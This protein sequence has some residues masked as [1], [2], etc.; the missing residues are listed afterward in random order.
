MLSG[1]VEVFKR[2]RDGLFAT[3]AAVIPGTVGVSMPQ[4]NINSDMTFGYEISLSHRNTVAGVHYWVTGQISATKNRWDHYLDGAASN[5]ME[6]WRRGNVS[7]RNK[8]IWWSYEEGGRYGN[9]NDI[10]YHGTLGDVGQQT[11]PGDYYYKDWNGDGVIDGNDSHPVATYNLPVF[12]YGFTIGAAWKGI[13]LATTWQGVAG[14]YSAYDEVFTE[15]G[16]FNGGA[17]LSY[18]TDRWHTANITDDP[19]NPHTQWVKGEY[20]ATGHSFNTGTTGIHNASY[21]RLKTLEV[22]YTLPQKWLKPAGVKDLRI[23]FNAYNLW[24]ITGMKNM[25]PERP[26]SSGG[27]STG[28]IAFYNYPINRTYN[29]G[30]TLKF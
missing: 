28:G 25:D 6:Y 8:D 5:S 21:L 15:V 24:T 2:K 17:S 19:W 14:V 11:L 9:Y 30:A 26:G 12:N 13:D 7:G 20:P 1:T 29:V 23:Y 18:Y 27:A 16:P 10:R 22:G 4:E 3:S